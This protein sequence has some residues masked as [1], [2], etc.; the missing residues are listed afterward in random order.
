M[1]HTDYYKIIRLICD[2]SDIL[3]IDVEVMAGFGRTGSLFA[4]DDFGVV[5]DMVCAAKGMSA[6]YSP[7]GAVIASDEIYNTV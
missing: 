1:P 3:L 2:H 5:P 4:I 6:G 7:L